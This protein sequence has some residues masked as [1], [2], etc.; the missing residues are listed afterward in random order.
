MSGGRGLIGSASSAPPSGRVGVARVGAPTGDDGSLSNPPDRLAAEHAALASATAPAGRHRLSG[1]TRAGHGPGHPSSD[2][3]AESPP[4]ARETSGTE[5]GQSEQRLADLRRE[6]EALLLKLARVSQAVR[7]L[8]ADLA[9]SRREL[10]RT[11][12]ELDSLRAQSGSSGSVRSGNDDAST[13]DLERVKSEVRRFNA[14]Y[15][16]REEPGGSRTA[17]D[18]GE[19]PPVA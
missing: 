11:Q 18:S 3:S 5:V 14:R 13:G 17:A 10:R 15:R 1:V 7:A 2:G 4:A 16:A 19:G 8:V 12:R 6:N 9:T